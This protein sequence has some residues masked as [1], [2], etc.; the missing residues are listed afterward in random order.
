MMVPGVPASPPPK[1]P[2]PPWKPRCWATGER[3]AARPSALSFAG[4]SAESPRRAPR[5]GA[6]RTPVAPPARPPPPPPPPPP[7]GGGGLGES[8]ARHEVNQP[9]RDGASRE[10]EHA[11]VGRDRHGRAD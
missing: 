11:G 3:S 10:I 5:A 7:A 8:D 9:G 6:P 2:P 1:P 4:T